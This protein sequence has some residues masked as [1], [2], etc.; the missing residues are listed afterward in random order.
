MQHILLF[1]PHYDFK[2]H[3]HTEEGGNDFT[4]WCAC[5]CLCVS[6]CVCDHLIT[7]TSAANR[8]VTCSLKA[9]GLS[10]FSSTLSA[11]PSVGAV[12][13]VSPVNSLVS[14]VSFIIATD[15]CFLAVV[16]FTPDTA[17]S[18]VHHCFICC[19]IPPSAADPLLLQ[20]F[21]IAE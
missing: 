5:V 17:N 12:L 21:S 16:T 19:F 20:C 2:A 9:P 11:V 13:S 18:Y 7:C 10:P 15:S 4:T 14:S 8:L 6:V 3:Q 1:L